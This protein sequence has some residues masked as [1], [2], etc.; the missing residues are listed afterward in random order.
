MFML[1]P[2]PKHST[3]LSALSSRYRTITPFIVT[4]RRSHFASLQRRRVC[5]N[6]SDRW[7]QKRSNF[8]LGRMLILL[9]MAM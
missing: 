9:P 8:L 6:D 3:V 7:V 2:L 5:G 1:K 4:A